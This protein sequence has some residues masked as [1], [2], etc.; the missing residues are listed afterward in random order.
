MSDQMRTILENM[1]KL[2]VPIPILGA[3]ASEGAVVARDGETESEGE[4]VDEGV[5]Q[6][7]LDHLVDAMLNSPRVD[8]LLVKIGVEGE[9]K[10]SLKDTLVPVLKTFLMGMDIAVAGGAQAKTAMKQM[11]RSV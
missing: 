11:A 9:G 10:M 2:I 4:G 3:E 8:S 7:V 1:N 5:S 6:S